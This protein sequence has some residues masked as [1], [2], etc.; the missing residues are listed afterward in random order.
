M[1]LVVDV[2]SPQQLARTRK[3]HEQGRVLKSQRHLADGE[4][5]RVRLRPLVLSKRAEEGVVVLEPYHAI[6][7]GI[8]SRSL[9][10]WT[11]RATCSSPTACSLNQ[12]R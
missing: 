1:P 8:M 10:P 11:N 9:S 12:I 4:V 7:R 2:H 6:S 5:E 3:T